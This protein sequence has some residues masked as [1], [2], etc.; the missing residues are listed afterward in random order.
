M[1]SEQDSKNMGKDEESDLSKGFIYQ[2]KPP[3]K[4]R[5]LYPRI[6][7]I[8]S[9]LSGFTVTIVHFLLIDKC[10]LLGSTRNG[11]TQSRS[12]REKSSTKSFSKTHQS[13]SSPSR[14]PP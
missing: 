13:L 11:I 3:F 1:L 10:K 12:R 14:K 5:Y 4:N 2:R 6:V 8:E 9:K 7:L